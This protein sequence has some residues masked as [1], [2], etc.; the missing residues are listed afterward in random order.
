MNG[1][2]TQT[3][4]GVRTIEIRFLHVRSDTSKIAIGCRA[5]AAACSTDRASAG[6]R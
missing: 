3:A 6:S 5:A 4:S 1:V 2:D